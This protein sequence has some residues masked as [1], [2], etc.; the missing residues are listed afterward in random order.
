VGGEANLYQQA[1]NQLAD[2]AKRDLRASSLRRH[3]LR[4][5]FMPLVKKTLRQ[6]AEILSIAAVPT[7]TSFKVVDGWPTI[8]SLSGQTSKGEMVT[9][10]NT[11]M[12]GKARISWFWMRIR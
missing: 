2:L 6:A 10:R 5:N 9:A 8:R 1:L 12:Q 7:K 4:V 11:R 3:H